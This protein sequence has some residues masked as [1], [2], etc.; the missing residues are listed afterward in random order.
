MEYTIF[1][2]TIENFKKKLKCK[3]K[4]TFAPRKLIIKNKNLK[5]FTFK[6]RL[7]T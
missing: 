6:I 2:M 1:L 4:P 3:Y 7:K 5:F